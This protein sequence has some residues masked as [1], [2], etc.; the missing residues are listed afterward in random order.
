M[1]RLYAAG[2]Q[3][4]RVDEEDRLVDLLSFFEL[5]NQITTAGNNGTDPYPAAG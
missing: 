2:Q 4:R 5:L 1:L 3:G